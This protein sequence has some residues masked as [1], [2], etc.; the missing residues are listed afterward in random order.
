MGIL[1]IPVH[2]QVQS[3]QPTRI[4]LSKPSFYKYNF[5]KSIGIIKADIKNPH[6]NCTISQ[7]SQVEFTSISFSSMHSRKFF[8]KKYNKEN[9]S[10]DFLVEVWD[11]SLKASV[12]FSNTLLIDLRE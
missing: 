1:P 3:Y 5:L 9:L 6:L 12:F 2:H 10:N 7:D 4:Q 11:Y 8:C